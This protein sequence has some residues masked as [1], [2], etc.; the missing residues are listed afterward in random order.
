[1]R[2]PRRPS[3]G[4]GSVS[5][6]SADVD[7]D[8][9]PAAGSVGSGGRRL[10]VLDLAGAVRV[11]DLYLVA[12]RVGS[13][14]GD[15]L[16]PGGVRDRCRQPGVAPDAVDGDFD[17][18]DAAVRRPGDARDRDLACRDDAAGRVDP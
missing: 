16:D 15:P 10:L 17:L 4:S 11:A 13:P 2:T 3:G 18:R 12:A 7:V 6:A 9:V 14:V 8:G 1:R 5:A